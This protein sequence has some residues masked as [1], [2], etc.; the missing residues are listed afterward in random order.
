MWLNKAV[1]LLLW[2]NLPGFLMGSTLDHS[3][4]DEV[5]RKN[6]QGKTFGIARCSRR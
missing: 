1:A 6:L 5:L 2:I 3:L 4:W